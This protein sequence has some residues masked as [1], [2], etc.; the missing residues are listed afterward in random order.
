MPKRSDLESVNWWYIQDVNSSARFIP[1]LELSERLYRRAVAPILARHF[2]ELQYAAGRLGTGS[3]VLGFDTPQSMDHDWGPQVD[4]FLAERAYS[5]ALAA[6][7]Q[8][9]MGDE[10]PFDIDGLSTHFVTPQV[11]GGQMDSTRQRPLTHKVSVTTARR[12]FMRYL[13]LD[14]LRPEGLSAVE[15]LAMPEQRLRTVSSG[16]VFR[17]DLGELEQARTLLHWYPHDVWLYLL[18]AQWR[19]IWQEEPFM[20]R[21]ADVGDDLGSRI[22]TARLAREL[23]HLCFLVERQYA[24]YP[25]W[26]GTAFS[27]L[28]CAERIGPSLWRRCTTP[29]ASP[30]RCLSPSRVFTIGPTW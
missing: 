20:A 10:L 3:E 25:K 15:W 14:P 19:R 27:R 2:P 5:D 16:A 28:E 7:I 26:F 23:M 18:A 6:E 24:P 29:S 21:C 17:D 1:G 13:G 11:H 9:I 8:R 22:E 4:L 30:S 12:F